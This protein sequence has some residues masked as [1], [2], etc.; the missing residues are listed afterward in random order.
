MRRRKIPQQFLFSA[1][2]E[3]CKGRNQPERGIKIDPMKSTVE[4]NKLKASR[5]EAQICCRLSADTKS[6][7]F[8]PNKQVLLGKLAALRQPRQP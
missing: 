1:A 4:W 3:T 2:Q 5:Q 7:A 6:A 8:V